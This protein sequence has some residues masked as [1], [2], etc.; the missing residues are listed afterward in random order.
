MSRCRS[1]RAADTKRTRNLRVLIRI[2]GPTVYLRE[3]NNV[4]FGDMQIAT[5]YKTRQSAV[6]NLGVRMCRTVN[7]LRYRPAYR[8]ERLLFRTD[9]TVTH[10]SFRYFAGFAPTERLRE[11][12]ISYRSHI[13]RTIISIIFIIWLLSLNICLLNNYCMKY[14]QF[15]SHLSDLLLSANFLTNLD[16]IVLKFH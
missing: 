16:A 9:V 1:L 5:S 15:T 13:S 2:S 7:A 3:S 4:G 11:N 12:F 8:M 10:R 6:S 14:I